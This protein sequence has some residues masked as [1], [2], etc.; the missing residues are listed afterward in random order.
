[1]CVRVRDRERERGGVGGE[2]EWIK[3]WEGWGSCEREMAR[4]KE[5]SMDKRTK[6]KYKDKDEDEDKGQKV[7][8]QRTKGQGTRDKE[9]RT[10]G[11]KDKMGK[12]RKEKR[13]K[14]KENRKRTKVKGH[15]K[16]EK[17]DTTNQT[18][19]NYKEKHQDK[20]LSKKVNLAICIQIFSAEV[21]LHNLSNNQ[22]KTRET[23]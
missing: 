21:G 18:K 12:R 7:K 13:G 14:G 22:Q 3:G 17:S 8:G 19:T 11:R 15:I 2:A 5:R 20:Y 23:D 6:D 9:Q 4:E 16:R 1:M 10:E